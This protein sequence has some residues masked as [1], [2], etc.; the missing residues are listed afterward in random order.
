MLGSLRAGGEVPPDI[1]DLLYRCSK[2]RNCIVHCDGVI[3]ERLIKALPVFESV[4]G[5]RL[6]ITASETRKFIYAVSW[7]LLEIQR[8]ILPPGFPR[9]AALDQEQSIYMNLLASDDTD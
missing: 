8:Q 3:D 4:R 9:R 6:G 7:Y 5:S 1:K 2:Y